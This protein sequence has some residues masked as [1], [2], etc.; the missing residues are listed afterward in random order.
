MEKPYLLMVT[1]RPG[2][3]KTTFAKNLGS[4]IFMPVISRDQIKEG[5]VH[6]FGK[7]HTELPEE[8]NEITTDIFFDT[9]MG[10][11]T[12]NVS[13]IVEAAF[14]HK[15]WSNRLEAFMDKARIVLLI[16]KVDEKVALDR[17]LQRGLSDSRREYFHG[18]KGV[19]LARKGMELK[20]SPYEEPKLDVPTF[21]INTTGEY[22]PAIEELGRKILDELK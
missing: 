15:L 20:V 22:N 19:D 12:N 10:L 8:T 18:D 9:V 11:I 14:Q 6:T 2:A 16:C 1:G 21:Y 17:F 3:G 4:E 5:Y 7:R 13:V